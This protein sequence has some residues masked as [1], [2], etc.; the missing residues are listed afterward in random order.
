[1]ATS[2]SAVT[3]RDIIM[4]IVRREARELLGDWRIVTPILLLAL[5]L[6]MLLVA[7]AGRI[8]G[9]L[10]DAS[11]A[12][13][14]I[15]FGALLVGFLPASFSLIAALES[16]VG[17][18]ERN[19]LETLLA[20]PLSDAELYLG[21]FLAAL[22]TPLVAS[23]AAMQIYVG[24]LLGFMPELYFG[25]MTLP[26]LL[27]LILL[28]CC[29]ALVMVSGAVVISAHISTVRAANL[30]SSFILVPMAG[31]MQLA[32][33]WII[34]E[35]WAQ[36]WLIAAA[37]GVLAAILVRA[38]MR[39]FNREELLAREHR[40][41]QWQ[42]LR[43]RPAARAALL[44]PP[45]LALVIARRELAETLSDW[46]VLLPLGVLTVGLPAALV[47]ATNWALGFVASA[48]VLGRLVPFV[49]VLVGFVP[50]SFALITAIESFVGERERNSLEALLA[51]PLN[52]RQLYTGKLV[53]ALLAPLAGS[54]AAMGVFLGL[55]RLI[56]PALYA[57]GMTPEVL[58]QI[59]LMLIAICVLMVAGAVVISTHTGSVRAATLL[60]SAVLLPTAV[61]VQLQALLFIA[62]RYDVLWYMLA[63]MALVA[64]ALI[65]SG[66]AG[67]NR[68]EILSREHED[69]SL[70]LL[71][72]RFR[73][74]FCEHQ[75]AGVLSASY[76]GLPFSPGRFY[77]Q[78]FPALLRELRL[79]LL[80]AL[81]AVA[82]GLALGWYYG[83]QA[84]LRPLVRLLEGLG[85]TPAPSPGLALGIFANNLRVSLLSNLLSA[86]SLG[87]FAFLV[88][89]V[90]FTQ[91]GFVAGALTA[92]GGEW[93][94]LGA[95][96]PSQFLLAYVLPHGVIELP[97]FVLSAALGLRIGAALL[98][99]PPGFTIGEN[100]LWSLAAFAKVWVLVL[101]PLIAVAAAVEGLISPLII[102]LLYGG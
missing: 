80:C 100:L 60:A 48:E 47:A 42:P 92:R 32:A 90:A 54:L 96:S 31:V 91:I 3:R 25:M 86:L 33:F 45:P 18:R 70:G 87:L 36:L 71:R 62:R 46:R 35:R 84:P 9:F 11:F 39:T 73:L 4:L 55:T 19:S 59:T 10:E 5:A 13:R 68:E 74:F 34:N 8:V 1:M 44:A 98:A 49:G 72:A 58:T 21:K 78:E 65:R 23:L 94:A 75:P 99:T 56:H 69:L 77:R 28:V 79:P 85:D 16:F 57:A 41:G 61:A 89:F 43:R 29:M 14:L 38:G 82:S 2:D 88:P 66:L 51:M 7:A 101:L 17:E 22:L 102:R 95:D 15:P 24:L 26:R 12:I 64:L 40:Q 52:D 97:A 27:L 6:P 53:A 37:L 83:T 50:A 30:M 93:L 76:A 67:F 63:A 20:M 81:L